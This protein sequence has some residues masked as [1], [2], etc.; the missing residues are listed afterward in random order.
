MVKK[1]KSSVKPPKV[2]EIP[3]ENQPELLVN[4]TSKWKNWWTRFFWTWVMIGAFLGILMSGPMY[5]IILVGMI[6]V[7]VYREVITIG[8]Q[9]PKEMNLPWMRFLHWYFLFTTNYFLYGESLIYYYK[10][11]VLVDAFL[12]PLATHHRFISFT[13]YITGIVIFVLNLKKGFYKFQFTYFG[14]THMALLLIIVESHF[15]ISNIFEGL[16]WLVLPSSLVIVNDIF[17]Y[18]AGFFFGKTPLIKLSPKKTWEGF[19]GGLIVTVFLNVIVVNFRIFYC[20][21]F[22]PNA[23][24]D[25]LSSTNRI[26]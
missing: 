12:M 19:I 13:L 10:P 4:Q 25:L 6:Q 23:L 20:R 24:Y 26:V 17:A 5:V 15:I 7:L 11:I 18:V 21:N 3:K 1:R 16:I 14:W 9:T 2:T 22:S 8:I